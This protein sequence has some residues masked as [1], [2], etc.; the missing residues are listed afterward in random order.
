MQ[1]A[2]VMTRAS[3]TESPSDP[4]RAAANRMWSQQ[5]GSLLVM[6]GPRLLGIITERDVMK[7]VA[8]GADLDA[9]PVSAVM[10]STVLTVSPDTSLHEAARHMATRWIRHLPVVDGGE[11]VGMV[12]QRDLCGVLAALGAEPES[13]QIPADDLVRSRRLTRIEAGDLD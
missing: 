7:A 2:E 12:S 1:V 11:V 6:D 8:R 10:T 5:T 4:L 13:G 3:V 9:T